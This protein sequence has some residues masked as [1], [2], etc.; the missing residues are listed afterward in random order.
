LIVRIDKSSLAKLAKSFAL[1]SPAFE[2][3][4]MHVDILVE[5][6]VVQSD[7]YSTVIME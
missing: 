6:T 7:L 4:A 1:V 5:G 3:T 2:K